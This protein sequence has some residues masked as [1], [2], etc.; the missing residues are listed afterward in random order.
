MIPKNRRRLFLGWVIFM[1]INMGVGLLF[2][3]FYHVTAEGIML[4]LIPAV[5]LGWF[6]GRYDERRLKEGKWI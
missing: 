6:L 4:I 3:K 1:L 5:I 2:A